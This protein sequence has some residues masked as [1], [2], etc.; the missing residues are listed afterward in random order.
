VGVNAT[1]DDNAIPPSPL[2][3]LA[4]REIN[5]KGI[6]GGRPDQLTEKEGEIPLGLQPVGPGL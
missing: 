4:C 6:F 2:D 1:G 3:A 5:P